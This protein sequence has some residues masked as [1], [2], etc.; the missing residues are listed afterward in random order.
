MMLPLPPIAE[1]VEPNDKCPN[2]GSR[3]ITPYTF[4]Y[5]YA[6][7]ASYGIN[8]EGEWECGGDCDKATPA[9]HLSYCIRTGEL[10][11]EE[12]HRAL[13]ALKVI[14]GDGLTKYRYHIGE[15][16]KGREVKTRTLYTNPQTYK[17]LKDFHWQEAE[18]IIAACCEFFDMTFDELTARISK[19]SHTIPRTICYVALWRHTQLSKSDIAT[20]MGR[21][22]SSIGYTLNRMK[23]LDIAGSSLLSDVMALAHLRLIELE[24]H[25]P[26]RKRTKKGGVH[27]WKAEQHKAF[28]KHREEKE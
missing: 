12:L 20:R 23:G 7:G 5:L 2:C 14:N 22:G 16:S 1:G 10:Q 15:D 18:S 8:S 9:A 21:D 28:D 25:E 4:N 19:L 6:C 24:V 13:A 11:P 3:A 17:E 26:A 27:P